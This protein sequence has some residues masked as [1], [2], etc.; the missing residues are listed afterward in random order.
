M[1][2]AII[3]WAGL[4]IEDL[5]NLKAW[6]DRI[7]QRPGSEKGRHVPKRHAALDS[8]NLTQEQIDKAAAE[9]RKWVQQ[10]MAEDAKK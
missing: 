3:D 6:V 2:S 10:G 4:D 5:P 7:L 1:I 9:A 8:K